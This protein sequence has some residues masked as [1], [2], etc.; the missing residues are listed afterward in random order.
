MILDKLVLSMQ[1]MKIYRNLEKCGW[2]PVIGTMSQ[3]QRS[4]IFYLQYFLFTNISS[5][6]SIYELMYRIDINYNNMKKKS[7]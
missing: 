5:L 1:P 7:I 3:H 6:K 2:W 4:R